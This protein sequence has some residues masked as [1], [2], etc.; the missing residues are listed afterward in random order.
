VDPAP[1]LRGNA[2][3]AA[4]KV[5]YPRAKADDRLPRDTW[6]MASIPAG[7][8]LD[9][10]GDAVVEIGYRTAE[11]S[12]GYRPERGKCFESWL[13]EE[14]LDSVEVMHGEGKV[15]LR[16]GVV[17]FPEWMKPTILSVDAVEGD[18]SSPPPRP[19]WIAYGDSV[20]EGWVATSPALTWPMVAAR[21]HGLD[22]VNMG[23]AGAARGEIVSAE[24]I[25]ELQADIIS[26]THG[27]NCWTRTPHSVEQMA[28]N[29]RSFLDVVRH[30]HPDTP[31]VVA[32]PIVRPDAEETPNILGATLADLRAA[33]ESVVEDRIAAGDDNLELVFG[34]PI[35]PVDQ[36]ADGI[37]PND[38]GHRALADAV[39][40]A[41][42]AAVARR[43]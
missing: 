7:V 1:F 12:A 25:S 9:F 36:L 42:A 23:Y 30:G 37:H 6:T 31:I 2:F 16:T 34:L 4:G 28:A 33:M 29:T 18:L 41:V 10:V 11:D 24:H 22:V 26:I 39:G 21:T 17:Y 38:A 20:L 35:V 3:P 15:R 8:R 13:D 40:P 19:R 5:A 43:G 27:T 14:L 32:S